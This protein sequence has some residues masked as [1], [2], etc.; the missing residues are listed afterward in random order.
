MSISPGA[1]PGPARD[2]VG[3][4]RDVPEARWPGDARVAI[5]LV[6]NW[7]EG[8]ELS[9]WFGD[10][11]N[12]QGLSESSA[13]TGPAVRDLGAESV[14]EYGSRAGIWRF[15][16][17][18]D[19]YRLP[20][21]FFATGVGML[22]AP[23][24]ASWA[25]EGGHEVAGHGL[26]WDRMWEF[27]RDEERRQIDLATAAIMEATGERPLGW[28]SRYSASVHTRELLVDAGYLYDSDA[29]ND[30]LPYY[31]AV[32]GLPHLVV[33]YSL[34]LNDGRFTS[35]PGYQTPSDFVDH[36]VR[37]LDELHREGATRPRMMSIGLHAR[38]IGQPARIS[39]LREFIEVALDRQAWFASRIEIARH[40]LKEHP[41]E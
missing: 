34:T 36:A 38:L 22:G 32:G 16:R 3:Y 20:T 14:Y 41:P 18:I 25:R 35:A 33:P 30:D 12:P 2:F 37:A 23:A 10:E 13:S 7:E 26:R 28:Y 1:W 8:S 39:A 31:T 40:W 17:L 27:D 9:F 29:Y 21:T 5:N 19:E 24:L 11:A 15:T 6:M 4:G